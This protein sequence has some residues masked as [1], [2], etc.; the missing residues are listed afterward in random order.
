MSRRHLPVLKE[1]L[2]VPTDLVDREH[3]DAFTYVIKKESYKPIGNDVAKK[4]MNCHWWHRAWKDSR[5]WTK[6]CH[7][8]GYTEYDS[9]EDFKVKEFKQVEELEVQTYKRRGNFIYFACGNLDKIQDIF[10]D[11]KI[12]DK[13]SSKRLGV[14]LK[15]GGPKKISLFPEQKSI[16]KK[17]F[18]HGGGVIKSGTGTGKGTMLVY[19]I[20]NLKLKTLILSQEIR[21]LTTVL[22]ELQEHTNILELEKSSGKK[23]AGFLDTAK[24]TTYPITLA[25]YQSLQSRRGR[26]LR[27]KLRNEFGLVWIEEVHHVA[28]QTWFKTA[29]SFNSAW[30][31]G[32]SATTVLMNET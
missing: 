8:L 29:T 27:K 11:L 16:V 1:R 23:I 31:G 4:C 26:K 19:I 17:W 9:C 32:S 13:R 21:H 7:K 6:Y 24:G 25:S 22:A 20:S 18:K 30:R 15:F 2:K 10:G 14:P 12:I 28:A 5:G 3:L